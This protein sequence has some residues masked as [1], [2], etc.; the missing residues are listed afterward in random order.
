[1]RLVFLA[2]LVVL[3]SAPGCGKSKT[4]K[5]SDPSLVGTRPKAVLTPSTALVGKI[6]SVNPTTR[7]AVLNFP[8]N[9]LPALEQRMNVYRK[10]LKVGE[11]KVTGPQRDDNI[12]ADITAGEAA[13]GDEVRD[14]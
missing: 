2:L 9:K 1:M 10:G 14:R 11:V 4:A 7:F 5:F 6:V 12:V 8:I 13:V 3:I